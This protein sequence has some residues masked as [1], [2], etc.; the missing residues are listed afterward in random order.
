MTT[1]IE[2]RF[3]GFL[4]V[5]VD[6]ETGGLNPET[7]ALLEIAAVTQR[8]KAIVA[9]CRDPKPVAARALERALRFEFN[10]PIND[11]RTDR[12]EVAISVFAK[13]MQRGRRKK[14]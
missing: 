9:L 13:W 11:V 3:R 2:K 14:R 1:S 6:V 8:D 7:D 5:V 12:H 4:P 10:L